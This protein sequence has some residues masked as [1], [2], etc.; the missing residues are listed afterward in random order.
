M[1]KM[2]LLNKDETPSTRKVAKHFEDILVF[3]PFNYL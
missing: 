1:L 3:K 2:L